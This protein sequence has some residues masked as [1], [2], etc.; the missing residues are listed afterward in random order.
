MKKLFLA[1]L[2]FLAAC[3]T[4][5]KNE[6][7]AQKYVPGTEDLPIYENFK[8]VDTKNLAYDSEGGSIIDANYFSN[9]ATAAEVKQFYTE[10]LAQLGWKKGKTG[11][12][13]REGER[14][15]L[16]ITE[17]GGITFLKFSIRPAS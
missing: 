11:E 8:P 17:K 4:L 9:H 7:L 3:G 6:R 2:L 5:E 12:Y 14:L 13:T 16:T 10:A 1:A 15:K